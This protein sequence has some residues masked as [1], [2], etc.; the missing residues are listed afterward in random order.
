MFKLPQQ[1]GVPDTGWAR[2]HSGISSP[3]GANAVQIAFDKLSLTQAQKSWSAQSPSK[4]H[5]P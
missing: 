3:I 2:K 5:L 4:P 1:R